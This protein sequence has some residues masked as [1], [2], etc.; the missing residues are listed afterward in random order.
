MHSRSWMVASPGSV[1]PLPWT[2]VRLSSCKN[3][4]ETTDFCGHEK[5]CRLLPCVSWPS[6]VF[7]LHWWK[8]E[9]TSLLHPPHW[10]SDLSAYRMTYTTEGCYSDFLISLPNSP[11]W[12]LGTPPLQPCPSLHPTFI[13][14]A[15]Q[16][17]LLF[18][19]FLHPFLHAVW[20]HSSMQTVSWG[21]AWDCVTPLRPQVLYTPAVVMQCVATVWREIRV[22]LGCF[23][24]NFLDDFKAFSWVYLSFSIQLNWDQWK[25]EKSSVIK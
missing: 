12:I 9:L 19:F 3:R 8:P 25:L 5:S 2:S 22:T 6:L 1:E 18:H 15:F 16:L 14:S 17:S 13:P 4:K 23:Q 21:K 10:T 20:M 11:S 24:L 7:T